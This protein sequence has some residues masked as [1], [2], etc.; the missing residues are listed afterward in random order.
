MSQRIA[1]FSSRKA[2]SRRTAGVLAA[3]LAAGTLLVTAQGASAQPAATVSLSGWKLTLPVNSSGEQSGASVTKNPAVVTAP[4]LTR[5]SSGTLTF[6][7]PTKG[8]TTPNSAHPRTE[9]VRT[10]DFTAGSGSHTLSSDVTMQQLPAGSDDI[11]IG[12]IHGSGSNSSVPLLMLHYTSGRVWVAVRKNPD[13]AGTDTATLLEGVPMN[14]AFSFHIVADGNNLTSS[15]AVTSTGESASKT[16]ALN[17]S[18]KG[19]AVRWQVGD[20]QQ[21]DANNSATDGGRLT[22]NYLTAN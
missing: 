4:W 20:Y 9:L 6:W 19:M 22:V 7:A 2:R 14:Q 18:F 1:R 5:N 10:S 8:A 16:I 11:I 17:S 13:V 3:V 12:Q 15:V 21:T